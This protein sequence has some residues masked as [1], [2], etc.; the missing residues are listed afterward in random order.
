MTEKHQ[1]E[2]EDG[3]RGNRYR[4]PVLREYGDLRRLTETDVAGTAT[5]D[6][7]SYGMMLT[8]TSG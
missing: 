7:G 3:T 1:A 2:A 4:K 5:P 8:K 6:G